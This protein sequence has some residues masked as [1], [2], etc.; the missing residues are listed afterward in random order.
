MRPSIAA[1]GLCVVPA[2][3]AQ[4]PVTRAAAVTAALTRGGRAA[5]A[6]AD[7]L[8]ARGAA[9]TARAFPNPDLSASYTKDAPQYH[10]VLSL[11]LDMPWI[12]GPRVGSAASAQLAA[13]YGFALTRAAIRFDVDTS[14]T[15]ALAAQSRAGLSRRTALDADSLLVIARV[16]REAGDVSELDVELAAINAAQLAN[17]AAADSLAAVQALLALQLAMGDAGDTV[18][19]ALADSLGPPHPIDSTAVNEPLPV[20][21]ARATLRSQ[22][23]ALALA[24]GTLF[25]PSLEIGVEREN[26]GG[27][28]LLPTVG[29]SLPLPLF[30]WNGGAIAAAAAARDRAGA[31]LD[32]ARRESAAGIAR[33]RREQVAALARVA[34]DE[35]LLAG[36]NRVA[37]MSLTAF[38]E[39]AAP[40]PSVLEAQ[41]NA[42]AALA[43]Y[44]DDLATAHDAAA[45]VQLLT[46][47]PDLP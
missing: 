2:L 27:T 28:G 5:L 38:R 33:A 4:T 23:R 10:A 1:L 44:I 11:P 42:R 29:F 39:G 14:Y 40:L 45:M 32:M 7:T 43:R 30:H 26:P 3:S 12:R 37:A 13:R 6:G 20:A 36:A 15:H 41:R 19:I 16:R 46:A 21:A 18:S 22:E 8:A 25:S 9:R 34:R 24:R 17:D 31:E 47:T 35:R